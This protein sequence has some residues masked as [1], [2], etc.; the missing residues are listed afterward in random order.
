[1]TTENTAVSA[2]ASTPC[3][4]NLGFHSAQTDVF[5]TMTIATSEDESLNQLT[6]SP[7]V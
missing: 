2:A 4:S 3:S 5:L 7:E 1:M 6:S